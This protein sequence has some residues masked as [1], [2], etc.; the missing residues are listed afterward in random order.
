M[1]S[2]CIS[3]STRQAEPPV[4]AMKDCMS[5]VAMKDCMSMRKRLSARTAERA[6]HGNEVSSTSCN[7]DSYVLLLNLPITLAN[8]D[9]TTQTL[10]DR[11]LRLCLPRAG[12][13]Y[14]DMLSEH[15]QL[16]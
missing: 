7:V 15:T 13:K 10:L 1:T 2:S 11:L 3:Q 5:I 6:I 12:K 9:T 16:H 14:S 4:V 8:A